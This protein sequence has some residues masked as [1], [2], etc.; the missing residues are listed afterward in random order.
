M[1][2]SHASRRQQNATIVPCNANTGPRGWGNL[3][4]DSPLRHAIRMSGGPS[5]AG[6][7][8]APTPFPVGGQPGRTAALGGAHVVGRRRFR[9]V[10]ENACGA[11]GAEAGSDAFPSRDVRL[12]RSMS[13]ATRLPVRSARSFSVDQRTESLQDAAAT[14]RGRATSLTPPALLGR[15]HK[16]ALQFPIVQFHNSWESAASFAKTAEVNRAKAN[17]MQQFLDEI[18]SEHA[19]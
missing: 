6:S 8:V 13:S 7:L 18:P 15:L 12:S 14:A 16:E 19:A 2:P 17:A 11:T 3:A 1:L 9:C 5:P 4:P 10:I